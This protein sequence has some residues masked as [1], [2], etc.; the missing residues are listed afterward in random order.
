MTEDPRAQLAALR[1]AALKVVPLDQA[2][3]PG[4]VNRVENIDRLANALFD[5]S[6]NA[7]AYRCEIEAKVLREMADRIAKEAERY[8][9]DASRE[10][11]QDDEEAARYW[12]GQA[13]ATE[14]CAAFLRAQATLRE[15]VL[16][17]NKLIPY[18]GQPGR[19]DE[20]NAAGETVATLQVAFGADG[21]LGVVEE[22]V[23]KEKLK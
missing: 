21:L 10:D 5:A 15:A 14:N 11:L 13:T 2:I 23:S 8:R 7:E 1:A 6:A 16:P 3:G 19:F 4:G 9:V 12:R 17:P 22:K 20:V 18:Q